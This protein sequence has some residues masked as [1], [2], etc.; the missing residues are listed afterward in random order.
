MIGQLI[1]ARWRGDRGFF[2]A[3]AAATAIGVFVGFAPSYYLKG[4]YRAPAIT[5]LVHVHGALFTSWIVLLIVQTSLVAAGRTDLHRRLGV[6]GAV[7]A[8]LM[9]AAAFETAIQATRRGRIDHA[10]LLVPIGTV[11]IFPALVGAAIA[12]RRQPALHKRLMLLATFEILSA[13]VARWPVVKTWST[14]AG[15]LAVT[16]L[17]LA[18]IVIYDLATRRRINPATLWG[19]LFLVASQILRVQVGH[20]DAWLSVARWLTS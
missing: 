2:T 11:V 20:T 8:G 15:F 6:A 14:P 7:L 13:A 10:F 5:P 9:A 18:A 4:W 17:F 1:G 16:D 12:Y 3:L 19:G